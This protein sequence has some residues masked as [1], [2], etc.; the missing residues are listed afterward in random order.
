MFVDEMSML[1][2]SVLADFEESV[3]GC[4]QEGRCSSSLCRFGNLLIV[5]LLDDHGQLG[6]CKFGAIRLCDTERKLTKERDKRGR[7]IYLQFAHAIFLE[8][9]PR[10]SSSGKPYWSCQSTF[11]APGKYI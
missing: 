1:S 9:M 4:V 8:K 5:V 2:C 11:H 7:L 6:P 3:R 10:Q